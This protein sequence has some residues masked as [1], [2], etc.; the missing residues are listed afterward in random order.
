MGAAPRAR[1]LGIAIGT[2]P[3]GDLNAI[4]DV[5][6]VRVGHVTVSFGDGPNAA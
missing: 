2:L 4:T 5:E 6:G 1:D 3:T